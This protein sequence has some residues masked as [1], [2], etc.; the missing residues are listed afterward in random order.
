MPPQNDWPVRRAAKRT[1]TTAADAR[2]TI[3]RINADAAI[4]DRR[5]RRRL[6]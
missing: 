5:K 2:I 1:P 6:A 4:N 3:A